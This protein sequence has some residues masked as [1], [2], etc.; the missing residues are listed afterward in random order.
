MPLKIKNRHTLKTKEIRILL[1][2]IK[3]VYSENFFDENSIVETGDTEGIKIIVVNNEPCF[4]IYEDKIIL[5]L[6]GVNH[7][8]PEKKFVVIDM[9]AIRFVINGADIM[10]PGIVDADNSIAAGDPVWICDEKNH[11]ALAI[12]L[13]L[14]SGEQMINKASGKAIKNIHYVGDKL[15]NFNKSL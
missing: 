12:G 3:S 5:T 10:A 11:K 8:K 1:D 7:F 9:G 13:A 14:I 4:F 6:F 15:W 2:K